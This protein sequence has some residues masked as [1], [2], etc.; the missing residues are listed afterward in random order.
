MYQRRIAILLI[1]SLLTATGLAWRLFSIS[2]AQHGA[3]VTEAAQQQSVTL[4]ILPRRGEILAEDAA[5]GQPS[6]LAESVPSY[7]VTATPV[8]VE[9]KAEYA[10]VLAQDTGADQP[11]IMSGF[12]NGTKDMNPLKHGL[13]K[14]QVEKIGTDLNAVEKTFDAK[15][16]DVPVNFSADQGGYI[17]FIGGVYFIKEFERVYPEGPLLS[18]VLGFVNN[19]GEGQY[20]FEAQYNAQLE[21]YT[22]TVKLEQDSLGTLLGQEGAALGQNGMNYELTI[23]RNVQF[24]AE[25]DL[26]QAIK[27]DGATGGSVII[28]DPKTGGVIAMANNPTYDANN[29]R[30]VTQDQIGLF[31]NASISQQWEPGSIFKPLVMAAALDAGS[32]TPDTHQDFGESVTVDGYKIETALRRDY[33]DENMAKVLANSDNVAM[34]W[35]AQKLGNQAMYTYLKKF[36]FG[37]YTGIDLKNEVAGKLAPA[38]QW[39]DISRSTISFGQGIAVTPLQVTSAFATIVNNGQAVTPHVVAAVIDQ[40]GI[41]HPEQPVLGAQVVKP[42]IAQEVKDMMVYTVVTAHAKAGTPGYK[43]GGKTGTAQIPDP[44]NGGYLADAY[45]HSFVGFGPADDPKYVMLIKIDHPDLQKIG[46]IYAESTAVP[47]FSKISSFLLSYYQIP[48]TNR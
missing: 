13:T 28:M 21:G 16:V 4:D 6:I 41:R 17:Y 32:V 15:H 8:N 39:S 22:G 27:D 35:I 12:E 48:P 2:V 30:D 44:V 20:G 14:E 38:N 3:Y 23:D 36:G 37:D 40:N 42:E 11:T 24:E 31:D 45:N 25:Q 18:Q 46:G 10:K 29:F 9:H 26:A 1:V 19:K 34:V 5:T 7:G 33:G 43:I 47:L